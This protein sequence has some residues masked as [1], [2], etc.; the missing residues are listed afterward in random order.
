M[1]I[2]LSTTTGATYPIIFYDLGEFTLETGTTNL[3]MLLYY[4]K[5]DLASS[6]N[7]QT[8]IN[9]GNI[10][11]KDETDFVTYTGTTVP[12]VYQT[13]S[14]FNTYTGITVPSLYTSLSIYNTF[15]GTTVPNTYQ[16][17]SNFNT[18]TGITA[19]ALYYS[20]SGG[21][22]TGSVN[23]STNLTING[24]T[25]LNTLLLKSG[26]TVFGISTATTL[27]ENSNS[28]LATQSA[29]KTYIDFQLGFTCDGSRSG[30]Q[31]S[32][33]DMLRS[34]LSTNIT[35][36]IV[37]YNCTLVAISIS[38]SASNTW[39]GSVL[40]NG[41]IVASVLANTATSAF[42]GALSVNLTAGDAIRLRITANTGT[43][44]NPTITAYFKKR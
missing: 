43:V 32:Y 41:T 44:N 6:S 24:N 34:G 14:I 17:I 39:T 33:I 42:D 10:I 7:L 1:Q 37:P 9:N 25:T 21:T 2:L 12:S 16:T 3:N 26:T 18:Y 19:S 23:V 28:Y 29:T 40:Q 15:T 8:N 36:F 38:T 13:I 30:N 35:P 27:I 5:E 4:T 11:L 31:N 20:K 22:I